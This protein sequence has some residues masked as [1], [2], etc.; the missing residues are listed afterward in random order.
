MHRTHAHTQAADGRT[1][2]GGRWVG[3]SLQLSLALDDQ[4]NATT[5]VFRD[6][7]KRV[8]LGLKQIHKRTATEAERNGGLTGTR[9]AGGVTLTCSKYTG[10]R[11]YD[12]DMPV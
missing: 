10:H 6:V 7:K 9:G 11:M 1:R 2:G 8:G 4:R 3:G 5:L 12:M